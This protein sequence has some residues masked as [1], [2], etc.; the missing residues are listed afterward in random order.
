MDI[1][2]RPAT[3]RDLSTLLRIDDGYDRVIRS[4]SALRKHD[5][6]I[7]PN[8]L[9]SPDVSKETGAATNSYLGRRRGNRRDE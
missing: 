6:S 9:A 7:A 1:T 3:I 4:L 8:W 5:V 2:F